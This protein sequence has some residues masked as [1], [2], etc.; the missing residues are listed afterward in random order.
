MTTVGVVGLGTMGSRIAARLLDSGYR[1][2]AT[3][4]TRSRGDGLIERGLRWEDT[5]RS[6]AGASEVVL[7]MVT[8]DAALYAVTSGDDGILAGLKPGQIYVDMSSVSPL[9][10]VR[11]AEQVDL[12]G[13]RMLDA[14]VSGSVPQVEQGRLTIMVGGDDAA[15][16]QVEPVLAHLGRSVTYVGGNGQGV[17]LKLA[18]NISLAVQTLAFSEGLL[19]AER[20][21]IDATRAAQVMSNSSIGSP[22]LKSRVPLLL[23]LPPE[24]WFDVRLMHKD[25]RLALQQAVRLHLRL[26]SADAAERVLSTADAMGYGSRDIAA[27]RQVLDEL[28]PDRTTPKESR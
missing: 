4:R 12:L 6:V 22:M 3:N 26:P 20:G 16:R 8:D 19:L 9:A 23:D 25:I 17:L 10:S 14:P 1:V 11:I 21:G 27:L 5:P 7:S 18:I 24:A 2:H 15:F 28:N 13:A